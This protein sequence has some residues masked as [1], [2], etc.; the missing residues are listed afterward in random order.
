MSKPRWWV[1]PL[2]VWIFS[3]VAILY[4]GM[5]TINWPLVIVGEWVV[6]L[7]PLFV[8]YYYI[9]SFERRR[10]FWSSIGIKRKNLGKGL[11]WAFAIFMVLV[12]V[13]A[14][15]NQTVTWL[16]GKSPG[17]EVTEH[18]EEVYPDWYFVY[19]LFAS[20]IPVGLFEEG[21]YRG[22]VLDRLMVKGAIFA[23]LVSSILHSSLHLWYVGVLGVTGIPLYGSALILF[24]F[25]GL[26]YVKS[27][28]II[29]L[30]LLHG[31][32]NATLSVRHFF[33]SQLV[34]AVW[35]GVI[36]VGALCL[37]YLAYGY[38]RET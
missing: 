20:F 23:I 19:F 35:L 15:Y 13:L 2:L 5:M 3:L 28:N 10:K 38:L 37:G 14:A 24:V 18:F 29:G 9:R 1:V 22:F 30:A 32:N 11:V 21:I 4:S 36:L 16:M 12:I 31:L 34:G 26:A 33:G 17:E 27:G 8:I 7:V 25:F 6:Y